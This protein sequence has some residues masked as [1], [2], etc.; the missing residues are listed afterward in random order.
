MNKTRYNTNRQSVF[1]R[2]EEIMIRKN[3][4][5]AIRKQEIMQT[6]LKLFVSKGYEK[7]TT[8]DI[9]E[10]LNLSRGGLYHHFHSK[11]EIL[12]TAITTLFQSE[13]AREEAIL[14]ND[15]ILAIDKLKVLIG[16]DS[17]SQP[18]IDDVMS[19]VHTKENPTLIT[20][21]LKKKLEIV[22]PIFVDILEQGI[23]EGI[24]NCKYPEEVSKIT[25]ILSTLLFSDTIVQ[26]S[27]QEFGRMVKVF[28][29]TIEAMVGAEPGT[30]DF[31]NQS[32]EV[33][34]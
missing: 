17:S 13:I 11:E 7:T 10:A 29:T 14:N 5:V 31:L 33:G 4:D 18:M 6:A 3:K 19:I 12:D 9:M 15:K 22:T 30:F 25:V 1:K 27:F 34:K 16:F 23:K 32:I 28:Q 8:N 24:F 20:H 21:L 2:E 26:M